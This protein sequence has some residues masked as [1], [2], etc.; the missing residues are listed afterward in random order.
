MREVSSCAPWIAEG[1]PCIGSGRLWTEVTVET[2]PD[3]IEL[4]AAA[5][6]ALGA[7]GVVI[8]GE[9]P[10]E[11]AGLWAAPPAVPKTGVQAYFPTD[12]LL[13]ERLHTLRL[14]LG[15][16]TADLAPRAGEF[17]ISLRRRDDVEWADA[18]KAHYHP[19]TVGRVS[20]VPR[21]VDYTAKPGEVIVRLDPGLAFGAGTHPTTQQSLLLLQHWLVPGDFVVDVGTGC[22]TLAIAA[23]LLGAGS[24]VARDIDPIAVEVAMDNVAANGLGERI[25]LEQ[26]D[27]VEGLSDKAD[28]VLANLIAPLALALLP[29]L[30]AVFLQGGVWC[31][32]ASSGSGRRK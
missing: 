29:A 5:L 20:V 13:G 30:S 1:A 7:N 21:W 28:L 15:Q 9:D 12:D 6:N 27:L 24:V 22:G 16:A 14:R 25:R 11:A 26:G 19:V 8:L 4:A 17:T 3:Q 18:W 10:A 32:P 23:S 31:W 2:R